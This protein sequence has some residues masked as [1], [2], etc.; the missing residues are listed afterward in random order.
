MFQGA[1][2]WLGQDRPTGLHGVCGGGPMETLPERVGPDPG[3]DRG[4][5]VLRAWSWGLIV[6]VIRTAHDQQR[7]DRRKNP[8]LGLLNGICQIYTTVIRG[9][10]MLGPAVHLDLRHLPLG[11]E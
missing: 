5:P 6:A 7:V 10:P 8:L 1:I 4:R 11:P 2:D 9:T 3:D